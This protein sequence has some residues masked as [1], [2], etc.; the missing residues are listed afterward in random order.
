MMRNRIIAVIFTLS[1]LICGAYAL[2]GE[3]SGISDV[4]KGLSYSEIPAA[5]DQDL[6]RQLPMRRTLVNVNGLFQK[7]IGRS[8]VEDEEADV[9][10]MSMFWILGT[11]FPGFHRIIT[12][13]SIIPISTGPTELRCG[14]PEASAVKAV[15][16]RRF[17]TKPILRRTSL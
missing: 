10:R 7:S 6:P 16:M 5:I 9:Y 11:A 13:C 4:I 1:I 3:G 8:F 12:L 15:L 14:Q 2:A 17:S